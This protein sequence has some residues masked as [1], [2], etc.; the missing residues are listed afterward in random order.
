[1]GKRGEGGVWGK[2]EW[3]RVGNFKSSKRDLDDQTK[4]GEE[5][6]LC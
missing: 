3:V 4:F 5:G 2:G 6:C 1:M